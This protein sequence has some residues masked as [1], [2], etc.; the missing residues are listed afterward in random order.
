LNRR[1]SEQK[2]GFFHTNNK[3]E[4]EKEENVKK[5]ERSIE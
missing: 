4:I 3:R 1:I 5:K 2:K